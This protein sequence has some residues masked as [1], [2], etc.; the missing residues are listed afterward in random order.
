MSG[1]RPLTLLHIADCHL[2]SRPGGGAEEAAFAALIGF[3]LCT[4]PDALIIAGDLFDSARVGAAVVEWTA[5]Q[6]DRLS[7][8]TVV[9]P[10]NHD[11]L[12]PGSPY[13]A[14]GFAERCG[15]ATLLGVPAGAV[16]RVAGGRIAVWGR[17]VV[18]HAPS[19]Q[20][21]AGAPDRPPRGTVGV[22]AAH[23]LFVDHEGEETV[24]GSPIYRGQIEAS[25]WQYLALGHWPRYREVHADPPAIYAGELA[26]GARHPGS[27]VL[28][29][30]AA[31]RARPRQVITGHSG[32]WVPASGQA[33]E[34]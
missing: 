5:A 22:I 33:L 30:F 20:P 2:G 27:A 14:H 18:D 9:L 31:G 17:P 6:L 11:A 26:P 1:G 8:Q 10:G 34:S 3:A 19:F 25:R 29:T 21:L 4:R 12:M 7:C 32:E 13:T 28:V 15:A 23:G 16:V 24:R